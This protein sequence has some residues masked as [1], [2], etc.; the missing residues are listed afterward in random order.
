[1]KKFGFTLSEL[2]ITVGIVGVV[3]ALT[4]PAVSNIMPDRNKMM[5]MKNY[6]EL[7]TITEKL[8]QDPE[9]YYTTYAIADQ[10][11]SC[12][13]ETYCKEGEKYANC[14]GL[15]C[16]MKP[17][18][19]EFNNDTY[20]GLTKYPYL[21]AK[22]LGVM[23]DDI[24]INGSNFSY[25]TEDG[26]FWK[27]TVPKTSP[28]GTCVIKSAPLKEYYAPSEIAIAINEK[29][30]TCFYGDTGCKKPHAFKFKIDI[31]G[32]VT[33]NDPLSKTYL[34]N[35]T[36]MNNKKWDFACAA[37]IK[38]DTAGKSPADICAELDD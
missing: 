18:K 22:H 12:G 4:A 27:I 32:N 34:L 21:L 11:Y 3:A 6:K 9:L 13:T 29:E 37:A 1:M 7:T 14:R 35:P 23:E 25:N 28:G 26:T 31:Y 5:F 17:H 30:I 38:A 36:R 2:L 10:D 33:P 15:S 19:T 16:D 8:L 20:S 24:K